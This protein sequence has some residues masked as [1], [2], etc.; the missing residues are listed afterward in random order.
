MKKRSATAETPEQMVSH[1]RDL[2]GEAEKMVGGS[3]SEYVG[4]KAEAL[5]ERFSDA[6]ERL[7]ELY[8]AAQEK[9]V[10]SAKTADKTI[11]AHPYESIAIALGVGVLVGALLRRGNN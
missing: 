9:V 1:L 10:D 2:L 4:E 11:R 6:Q 5:R 3:A 8:H 7:S